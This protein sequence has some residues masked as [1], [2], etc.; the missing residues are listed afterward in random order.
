MTVPDIATTYTETSFNKEVGFTATVTAIEQTG[1]DV[2]I[3]EVRL[4]N[5]VEV[6][7]SERTTCVTGVHES[8]GLVEL[9]ED[10]SRSTFFDLR[11]RKLAPAARE[12][13]IA[14]PFR[15]EEAFDTPRLHS[16]AC[17]TAAVGAVL[18]PPFSLEVPA[19]GEWSTPQPSPT[20][21]GWAAE[22]AVLG[23][24]PGPSIACE[25][26][27]ADGELLLM[28]TLA[29]LDGE[30]C[31]YLWASTYGKT[32]AFFFVRCHPLLHARVR[33]VVVSS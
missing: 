13:E 9:G 17:L 8:L 30:D 25:R 15:R 5:E 4:E 21:Q 10:P 32:P 28:M 7:R 31:G 12:M 26:R 20:A 3:R 6:S 18:A 19:V 29:G 2:T 33:A 27:Q 22:H 16:L 23:N 14:L 1:S 24:P 11:A